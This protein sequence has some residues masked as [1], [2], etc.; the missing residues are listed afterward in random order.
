M[1]IYDSVG[2]APA[3][4]A[5]VEDF[6][7]RILAD[8][9]LAPMFVGKDLAR[10]KAQQR[11]FIAAALGGAEIYAGREMYAAHARIGVTG[12]DFD[13]VVAH[14]VDTLMALGVPDFTITEIGAALSPLREQIVTT[15]ARIAG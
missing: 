9:D 15:A 14:L 1:T 2:G 8:P 13:A 4:E 7:R 5:A 12:R 6:Y 11:A 10:L 3:V